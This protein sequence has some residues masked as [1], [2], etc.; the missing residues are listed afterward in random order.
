MNEATDPNT[1][2]S[3]DGGRSRR[4]VFVLLT[5]AISVGVTLLGLEAAFRVYWA[6][7]N[8]AALHNLP[9]LNERVLIPSED[10]ELT[11]ELNP[12]V[13]RG[14]VSINAWGM[15]DDD[16]T[17]EKPP[18]CFRIAFVG[19][20]ISCGMG[21]CEK[22]ILY[23]DVLERELN[24]GAAAGRRFECLNFSANGYSIGQELRLFQR[25]VRAFDP[26]VVV[27]QSCLNDPYPTESEYVHEQPLGFSRLRTF[28][29]S[30]LRPESFLAWYTVESNYDDKGR[31]A[32]LNGLRGFAREAEAG[33]PIV[34]VLFPYLYRPAYETWDFD[35][36]HRLWGESATQAGIPFVDLKAVFDAAG[37]IDERSSKDPLHPSPEGNRLAAAAIRRELETRG[38]LPIDNSGVER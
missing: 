9:P 23:H 15:R 31:A 11:Y 20:S 25:R 38:L 35:R 18:G 14:D 13:T 21:L 37:E 16:I 8:R 2:T 30:R 28:V 19:D 32:V 36:F 6:V 22:R 34:V 3:S 27:I 12:G 7:K 5:I 17:L 10:P 4:L 29:W 26:D 24:A 1:G 33:P